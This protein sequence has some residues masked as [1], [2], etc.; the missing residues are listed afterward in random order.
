MTRSEEQFVAAQVAVERAASAT[1]ESPGDTFTNSAGTIVGV[2]ICV[3]ADPVGSQELYCWLA[4]AAGG[5][6]WIA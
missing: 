6:V 5:H 3:R 4:G 1:V 2:R